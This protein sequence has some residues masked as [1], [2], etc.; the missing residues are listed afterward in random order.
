MRTSPSSIARLL[1]NLIFGFTR[2]PKGLFLGYNLLKTGNCFFN[3][4]SGLREA[5]K[6][7]I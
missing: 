5:R 2:S 6:D 1:Q 3:D 4:F 7:Y